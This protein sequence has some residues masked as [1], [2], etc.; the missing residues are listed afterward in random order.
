[1]DKTEI[2]LYIKFIYPGMC[3][4]GGKYL[5]H[6]RVSEAQGKLSDS[7]Y[8]LTIKFVTSADDNQ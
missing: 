5:G 6:A 3:K 4:N 7:S 1:M 2:L 8:H